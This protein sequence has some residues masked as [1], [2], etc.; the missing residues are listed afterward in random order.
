MYWLIH[1]KLYKSSNDDTNVLG[2]NGKNF[3][4]KM[5]GRNLNILSEIRINLS[6]LDVS[7]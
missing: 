4:I 7:F 1:F 2:E 3:Q 5:S 6:Y